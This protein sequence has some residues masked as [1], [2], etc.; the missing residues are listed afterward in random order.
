[1]FQTIGASG[2]ILPPI[3]V[4][5]TCFPLPTSNFLVAP[6]A[7]S[8]PRLSRAMPSTSFIAMEQD[9]V[10][11]SGNNGGDSSVTTAS[12]LL[13]AINDDA[14][15]LASAGGSSG[16]G[17]SG[18]GITAEARKGGPPQVRSRITVVCAEC[19][20]L[21]LKCDR[22]APCSS[23]EKRATVARCIYSPAAAE[24]VDLH[25]L[26]NRL[27]TVEEAL[28]TLKAAGVDL[29]SHHAD[30]MAAA[31]T[32]A[33]CD[34]MQSSSSRS[35]GS[36]PSTPLSIPLEELGDMW[37]GPLHISAPSFPPHQTSFPAH[38]PAEAL[39][40]NDLLRHM[41][42]SSELH[43]RLAAARRA[44]NDLAGGVGALFEWDWFEARVYAFTGALLEAGQAGRSAHPAGFDA[45]AAA[46]AA[47]PS[48]K[49]AKRKQREAMRDKARAIF[50]GGQQGP[51]TS[52][53]SLSAALMLANEAW[54][55]EMDEDV[56]DDAV[57]L[58]HPSHK[59]KQRAA[60]RQ[61]AQGSGRRGDA[62][63][64]F[65]SLVC[66]VLSL[67]AD[68]GP[69]ERQRLAGLAMS[70][71]RVYF[72]PTAEALPHPL[73]MPWD[74]GDPD[75]DAVLGMWLFG[76]GL[77]ARSDEGSYVHINQTLGY[78]RMAGLDRDAAKL[79]NV[80]IVDPDA[81]E[82]KTED[83]PISISDWRQALRA[84]T[85]WAL[86][87]GDMMAGDMLSIGGNVPL[88]TRDWKCDPDPLDMR[89]DWVPASD[90]D[91]DST[92]EGN[93]RKAGSWLR[94][95]RLLHSGASEEKL[96][97]WEQEASGSV[98][99]AEVAFMAA[100]I[101][102][103]N[104]VW[105]EQVCNPLIFPPFTLSACVFLPG[106]AP[107]RALHAVVAPFQR[108]QCCT[109]RREARRNPVCAAGAVSPDAGVAG[110]QP[111]PDASRRG[112][113]LRIRD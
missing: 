5:S 62:G 53:A 7:E 40:P 75:L 18:N 13:N 98:H 99:S 88:G 47:S 24:K 1:R 19:K 22:K 74:E 86:C 14:G 77:F 10:L 64:A 76:V 11:D 105:T 27:L 60:E 39:D 55:D 80:P 25:S 66:A 94:L 33:G 100:R 43:V 51:F 113:R 82:L 35:S 106:T 32:G 2:K 45:S 101:K 79:T 84:R 83:E 65:F 21:K 111:G 50:S 112:R 81:H 31:A 72:C 20:R 46:A 57:F 44:I 12:S 91:A 68:A 108:G 70:A 49:D 34:N 96:S 8:Q 110:D 93:G 92:C 16:S 6:S 9:M 67:S 17:G 85:W 102:L 52:S 95:T 54:S 103:R 107:S 59:G 23:C 104:W 89:F 87:F 15:R 26:N 71:A 29:G 58:R 61:H 97:E 90:C 48:A 78:A 28:R 37:L 3:G 38:L 30:P 73:P 109:H 63:L 42:A 36:N 56:T 69:D 4:S 41:P